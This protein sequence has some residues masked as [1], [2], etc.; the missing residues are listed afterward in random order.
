M[1]GL[2][3]DMKKL[4]FAAAL[5]ATPASSYSNNDIFLKCNLTYTTLV[6][7]E[8][9]RQVVQHYKVQNENG[10]IW[11]Y[12]ERDNTYINMCAKNKTVKCE[13]SSSSIYYR[14]DQS[15][16]QGK[17][18]SSFGVNRWNGSFSGFTETKNSEGKSTFTLAMKGGCE[19]GEDQILQKK[20]F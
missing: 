8:T 1:I 14:Q 7:S 16:E 3:I 19:A 20:K 17:Y 2:L 9:S 18:Y 11:V 10:N 4:F 12:D 15:D 13:I 6:P 5:I